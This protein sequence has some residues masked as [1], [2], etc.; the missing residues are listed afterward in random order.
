MGKGLTFP[1]NVGILTTYMNNTST[2]Q[3]NATRLPVVRFDYP[4]SVTNKMRERFVKVAEA[5]PD[6]IKGEELDTPD[7]R[8]KG[9]FKAYL[10]NR[11]AKYGVALV[12]F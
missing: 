12:Q 10:R 6:Y 4:D 3:P 8:I 9:P 5:T 1:S 7:S 11:I 2:S